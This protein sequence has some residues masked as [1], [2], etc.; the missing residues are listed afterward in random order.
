M[1]AAVTE[2]LRRGPAGGG[3]L[4]DVG[5]ERSLDDVVT[6]SWGSLALRGSARCLVCGTIVTREQE[7][8]APAAE[9]GSC[10][11]LLD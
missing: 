8:G 6:T 3:R 7:D 1:T 4:F 9:C 11:S 5:E 10:G 2:K